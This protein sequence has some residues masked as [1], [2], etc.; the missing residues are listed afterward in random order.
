M[1]SNFVDVDGHIIRYHEY[2]EKGPRI[3]LLHGFG[4]INQSMN[5][6]G[7]LENMSDSYR[8][9]ALDLL[10][11]GKSSDPISPTGFEPHAKIMQRAA[12][13]LG[14]LRFTLIGYSFGGRVSLRLASQFS[15]N[16]EKLVLVDITPITFVT[17]QQITAAPSVPFGFK[18]A[19]TAVDWVSGRIPGVPRAFWYGNLGNMFFKE[20][21]GAW[22]VASHPTRKTQLVQ[23]GDGWSY[24]K[25]IKVSTMIVRGS[26]SNSS[27]EE[28][29]E[30]M[31]TINADLIVET[32]EGADH[33]LP[34]THSAQFEKAIREFIPV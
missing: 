16:V 11:H 25:D 26:E 30:R 12:M 24:F 31:K 2:G 29:V 23:D 32:I 33:N 15:E 3:V 7:F 21:D 9:L 14:Y 6:R 17:P 13:E 10:G 34:F 28:D 27:L 18:D 5:F 20:D 8:V 19:D 1:R 4:H 22:R